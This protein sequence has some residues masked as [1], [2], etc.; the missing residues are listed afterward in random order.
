MYIGLYVNGRYYGQILMKFE[1]SRQFFEKKKSQ[2]SNLTE[3][4]PVGAEILHEDG[5]MD[6]QTDMT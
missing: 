1:F 5:L 3:I 6:R 2:L 4:R